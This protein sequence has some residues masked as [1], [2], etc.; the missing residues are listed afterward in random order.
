MPKCK[1]EIVY[2]TIVWMYIVLELKML[3]FVSHFE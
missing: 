2:M 1:D 3:S